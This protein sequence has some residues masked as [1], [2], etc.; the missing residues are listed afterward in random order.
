MQCDSARV[1]SLI[2]G[3]GSRY[4]LPCLLPLFPQRGFHYARRSFSE[5]VVAPL[6]TTVAYIGSGAFTC[7][8]GW[9][10][11]GTRAVQLY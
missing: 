11:K 3:V 8:C 2:E 4:L 7:V 6:L 9:P 5:L 10:R 1:T